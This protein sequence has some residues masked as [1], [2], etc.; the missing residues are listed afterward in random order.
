[1]GSNNECSYQL[2]R[3]SPVHPSVAIPDVVQLNKPEIMIGRLKQLDCDV[4]LDSLR[5]PAMISRKHARLLQTE[6]DGELKWKIVDNG[7]VNGVFVD[8]KKISEA[9]LS[10]GSVIVFG[11]GGKL[12]IGAEKDQSKDSEFV[13]RFVRTTKNKRKFEGEDT[14]ELKKAKIAELEA[15]ELRKAKVLAE[16]KAEQERKAREAE[17]QLLREELRIR[18]E[19]LDEHARKLKELES[20]VLES[21]AEL[22][23][24]REKEAKDKEDLLKQQQSSFHEILAKIQS[25][26][27]VERTKLK[28]ET[29]KHSQVAE[30]VQKHSKMLEMELMQTEKKL[31]QT[32]SSSIQKGELEEELS[33]PI[34]QDLIMYAITL[35]CSH[36]FCTICIND[37]K[38]R[39]KVCPVCRVAIRREPIKSLTVDNAVAKIVAKSSQADRAEWAKRLAVFKRREEE[40]RR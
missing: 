34:C 13:Y 32:T 40:A 39:N 10:D 12:P 24:V 9:Y 4:A 20:K 31:E 35:E 30:N 23:R 1:M 19:A 29:A 33:C 38:D 17:E 7:S 21:A 15:E 14:E 18:S 28:E 8:N 36:S 16:E 5:F 22:Q 27:E 26:F 37:W 3:I 11:G 25:D 6:E 2:E